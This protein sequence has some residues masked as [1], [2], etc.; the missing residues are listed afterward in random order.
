MATR[1]KVEKDKVTAGKLL[2]GAIEVVDLPDLDIQKLSVRVDTG[3]Q[4][5]SLHATNVKEITEDGRVLLQFNTVS[6]IEVKTKIH[7]IRQIK[8]SN[9]TRQKRYVIETSLKIGSE[10][11]PI[12]LT[13]TDRSDMSFDMLLGRE[14][15]VGRAIVDPEH[16][17]LL[18]N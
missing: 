9:G 5:S 15:M 7:D 13:L 4:T 17:Y 1:D 18:S 6:G 3:A 2:L 16:N 12:E 14:G 10:S 8:S 11:W